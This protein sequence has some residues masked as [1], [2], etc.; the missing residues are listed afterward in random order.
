M[1]QPLLDSF[2]HWKALADNQTVTRTLRCREGSKSCDP[3]V[4]FKTTHVEYSN[5]YFRLSLN[6]VS[7]EQ[8]NIIDVVSFKLFFENPKFSVY[9]LVF[10]Y[11]FFALNV[12]AFALYEYQICKRNKLQRRARSVNGSGNIGTQNGSAL[13][14]TSSLRV[15][16]NQLSSR[17]WVCISPVKGSTN[18]L[19]NILNKQVRL[20]LLGL[21]LF[22]NPVN[23]FEY[24][25]DIRRFFGVIGVLFELIFMGILFAFWLVEFDD[26]SD[27]DDLDGVSRRCCY[28]FRQCTCICVTK[29]ALVLIFLLVGATSYSWIKMKE[30]S[31]PLYDFHEE[32]GVW[33]F[34]RIF[35]LVWGVLYFLS[36][37]YF[38]FKAFG[39]QFCRRNSP[40]WF[41][42]L[43]PCDTTVRRWQQAW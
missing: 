18:T 28:C 2:T 35:L 20:L 14:R 32:T 34:V 13:R 33:D 37:S 4:L 16:A 36:L 42:T 27:E 12:V 7:T 3:L 10:K 1:L 11:I 38:V 43:S 17:V 22:N 23:V 19:T 41:G 9:K 26:L 21:M 15:K 40:S 31:D 39:K 29:T 30:F 25:S 24:I 5:Y 6:D 8:K